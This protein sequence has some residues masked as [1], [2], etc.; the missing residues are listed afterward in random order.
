MPL[1]LKQNS[2]ALRLAAQT[3]SRS[4]NS[5]RY[6]IL[7]RIRKNLFNVLLVT[8][9][10]DDQREHPVRTRITGESNQVDC[11]REN[12]L[13]PNEFNEI[14]PKPLRCSRRNRLRG[15]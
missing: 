9:K 2:V 1:R 12:L 13:L 10:H 6:S 4:A 8:R 14:V 11:P 3:R 15:T 7:P 5:Y